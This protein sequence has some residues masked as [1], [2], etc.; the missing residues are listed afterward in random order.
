MAGE[1]RP[2]TSCLAVGSKDVDGGAEPRHD[3]KAGVVAAPPSIP[4][5]LLRNTPFLE[6]AVFNQY[7]AE[8]EMLRYL[9]RLEEKDIA[10]NR[11]MIPLGSCTMKLNASAEMIPITLPGFTDIHPFAPRR[12]DA[13]LRRTDRTPRG[14]AEGDHRLCGRHAATERWLA[15]RVFRAAGDPRVSRGAGR[16]P[17]RH[18]PDPVQRA[19]HQSG[20]RCDGRIAS[21]GGRLRPRRQHRSDRSAGQ[22]GQACR[23]SRGADGDLSKHAWCVRGGD[24]RDLR[25]RACAWWPGVHGWRQPQRAGRTDQ[26]RRRSAPMCAT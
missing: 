9:K 18:L 13:R 16:R 15:G 2:S 19:R 26:S 22:G 8:H 17:S 1:G 12:P 5:E 23:A 7:H 25:D 21:G 14:L 6:Q 10:L 11:S 20:E 24:T 4:A 3:E